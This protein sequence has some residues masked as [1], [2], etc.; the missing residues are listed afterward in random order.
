MPKKL[1]DCIRAW[2]MPL[3]PEHQHGDLLGV[4][5]DSHPEAWDDFLTATRDM[6]RVR[7][8]SFQ[9]TFPDFCDLLDQLEI[10]K[11]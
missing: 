6:D 5:D 4:L 3:I 10:E 7:G 9:E 11:P 2:L 1:R 8:Q